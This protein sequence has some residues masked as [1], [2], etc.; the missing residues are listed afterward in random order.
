[1]TIHRWVFTTI[2]LG[3]SGAG[4]FAQT[5]AQTPSQEPPAGSSQRA[6]VT[7]CIERAD[8]LV[9]RDALGTTVDSLT[10]VLIKA[11]EA[12]AAATAV[13]TSGDTGTTEAQPGVGKIYRLDGSTDQLNSHV[14]HR[15]EITGAVTAR[16]A[17]GS[18]PARDPQSADAGTAGA[19]LSAAQAPL[20]RAESVKLVSE[21]CPR[22]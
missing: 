7:G 1:M 9:S 6:V 5:A 19:N 22:Q 14:G 21:T 18:S 4:A 15:V 10:F 17:A 12:P 16:A 2:V 20:L 3:L 11:E 8:Q 13:G